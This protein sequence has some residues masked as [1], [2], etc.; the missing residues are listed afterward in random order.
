LRQVESKG[1]TGRK[2]SA[3]SF[4]AVPTYLSKKHRQ[5]NGKCVLFLSSTGEKLS[6][7]F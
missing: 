5:N 4:L 6:K 2:I 7:V 3:T 1:G